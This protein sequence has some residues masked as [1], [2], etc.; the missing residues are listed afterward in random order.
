MMDHIYSVSE[1]TLQY[2]DSVQA[3]ST[4][5][6]S[7]SDRNQLSGDIELL[8]SAILS[9]VHMGYYMMLWETRDVYASAASIPLEAIQAYE[10][11]KEKAL[12]EE[13]ELTVSTKKGSKA[14]ETKKKRK[15]LPSEDAVANE[16]DEVGMVI[17]KIN[18]LIASRQKLIDLM[19]FW[20]MADD[21]EKQTAL[22]SSDLTSE[23]DVITACKRK[24]SC[25]IFRILGDI[26]TLFPVKGNNYLLVDRLAWTPSH[27]VLQYMRN[28]FEYESKVF[29]DLLSDLG[30]GDDASN[31]TASDKVKSKHLSLELIETI[32]NPLGKGMIYDVQNVNRRQAAAVLGHIMHSTN[33]VQDLIRQWIKKIKEQSISKYLE[34]QMVAIKAVYSDRVLKSIELKEKNEVDD[35]S[36][37]EEDYDGMIENGLEHVRSLGVRLAQTMGV[38][39]CKDPALVN[40]IHAMAEHA[41]SKYQNIGVLTAIEPYLRLVNVNDLK[42]LSQQFD[43]I[44]QSVIND[45]NDNDDSSLSKIIH[46]FR[47]H[48]GKEGIASSRPVARRTSNATSSSFHKTSSRKNPRLMA[49]VNSSST[50]PER[51]LYESPIAPNS[52]SFSPGNRFTLYSNGSDYSESSK[53]GKNKPFTD[54]SPVSAYAREGGLKISTKH[55]TSRNISVTKMGLH[56]ED[57]SPDQ[58]TD[59]ELVE[60]QERLLAQR[61]SAAQAMDALADDIFMD[62]DTRPTKR[63][64]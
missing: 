31:M 15:S 40:F 48:L 61:Q 46:E 56:L 28:I 26:R 6:T 36:E 11:S 25:E 57:L 35:K 50:S 30:G 60:S 62:L 42:Q 34:I 22:S 19:V 4:K 14:K 16:D 55:D 54:K 24:V 45:V 18:I 9:F 29:R 7:K 10:T 5:A 64:R 44:S 20:M 2:L 32:L 49:S 47:G 21:K 12:Q 37:D 33:E 58:S 17:H 13:E 3:H 23:D 8:S 38:G 43:E 53:L 63:H 52:S 1:T 27:D 39:K 59:A 41:C 51:S